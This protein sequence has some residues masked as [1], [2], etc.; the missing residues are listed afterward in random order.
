MKI[1]Q[2]LPRFDQAAWGAT[3]NLVWHLSRELMARGTVC[4]IAATREP[5]QCALEVV[6]GI[7]IHRFLCAPE[8][9]RWHRKVHGDEVSY[10]E[11]ES[12]ALDIFLRKNRFDLI[13]CFAFGSLV[14]RVRHGCRDWNSLYHALPQLRLSQLRYGAAVAGGNDGTAAAAGRSEVV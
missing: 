6:D 5:E 4:T 12:P 8:R 9:W 13:H 14:R 1:L 7:E 10:D 2:V 3:E 11:L